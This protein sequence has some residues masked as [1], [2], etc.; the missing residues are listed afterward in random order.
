[1]Y[2]LAAELSI[3]VEKHWL[4][5]TRK[6][7]LGTKLLWQEDYEAVEPVYNGPDILASPS[8]SEWFSNVIA[9]AIAWNAMVLPGIFLTDGS[10]LLSAKTVDWVVP[11]VDL[12]G[13]KSPNI[14]PAEFFEYFHVDPTFH[15]LPIWP[16]VRVPPRRR[17]ARTAKAARCRRRAR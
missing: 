12:R 5:L 13:P 14:Y 11:I 6:C 3:G 7:G 9:E 17:S 1:L 2:A 8:V 15:R 10:T 4:N 16:R